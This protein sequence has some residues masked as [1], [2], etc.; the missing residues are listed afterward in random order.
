M[1]F[2]NV[3]RELF[4]FLDHS[5]NAFFAVRNMCDLLEQ[6]GMIRLYEGAPWSLAAGRGYY[7]TRNDSAVI[8]FRIPGADYTGF[9]MMASHCDSPVFKIKANAE[10]TIENQ[11]VKLNVEKYGGM[12]CAPWL[13]RPLSVAGRVIVR[14]PDGIETRLVNIDR[15]LLIIPNLA[16]H[17]NRQVNDGYKFN[18]QADMLPLF[19]EK[20]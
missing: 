7:V 19:C 10:I 16:I 12:L 9:Q 11:Y 20:G 4:S 18:A 1:N 3:N 6:A 2:D 5:P 8:A 17:M 13:D 14:T 15:D